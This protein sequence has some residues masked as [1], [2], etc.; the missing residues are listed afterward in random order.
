M[1]LYHPRRIYQNQGLL[2]FDGFTIPGL[3]IGNK[4]LNSTQESDLAQMKAMKESLILHPMMMDPKKYF[5]ARSL[6]RGSSTRFLI[7][8]SFIFCHTWSFVR[9]ASS[10][11]GRNCSK[12]NCTPAVFAT[13]VSPDKT[14]AENSFV[15]SVRKYIQKA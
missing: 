1:S 11:N 7:P 9:S 3:L 10:G 14:C 12:G 2:R 6:C 13:P 4:F 8:S 5:R 15:S